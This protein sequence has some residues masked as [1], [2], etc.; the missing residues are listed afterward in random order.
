[1]LKVTVTS[2]MTP[3][4]LNRY[5]EG[6]IFYQDHLSIV[7]MYAKLPPSEAYIG[8]TDCAVAGYLDALSDDIRSI[9]EQSI[10]DK[11]S[12]RKGWWS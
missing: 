10:I 7:S 9:Q 8:F 6:R 4:Q 5:N 2:F 1:M 3:A 11:D 12:R